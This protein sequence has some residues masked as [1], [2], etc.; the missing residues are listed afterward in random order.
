MRATGLTLDDL[1]RASFTL[2]TRAG[3]APVTL[4]LHGGHHVANALAAAAVAAELGM[5]GHGDRGRADRRDRA[6]QEAH[7]TA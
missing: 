7:G 6:Q 1:G 4:T 2:H 3:S 5:D